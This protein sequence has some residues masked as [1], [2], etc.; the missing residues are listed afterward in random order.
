MANLDIHVGTKTTP[1][2]TTSLYWVTKNDHVT[3]HNK[4]AATLTVSFPP[5]GST[6]PLCNNNEVPSSNPITVPPGGNSGSDLKVCKAF[7][8]DQFAYTAQIAGFAAEDPIVIIER[9]MGGP[10]LD[11]TSVLIGLAGGLLAGF[12]LAKLLKG[13]KTRAPA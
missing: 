1:A 4:G 8:A 11:A 5:Q 7:N 10:K 6:S 9:T 12:I 3:F 13:G 2:Q